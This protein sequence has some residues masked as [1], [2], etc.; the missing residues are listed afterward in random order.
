VEGSVDPQPQIDD[1]EQSKGKDVVNMI[2]V[3]DGDGGV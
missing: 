2:C 1:L 3:I